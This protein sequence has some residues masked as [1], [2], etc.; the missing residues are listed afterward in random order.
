M[1]VGHKEANKCCLR[2]LLYVVTNSAAAAAVKMWCQG[3][4][5]GCYDRGEV[6]ANLDNFFPCRCTLLFKNNFGQTIYEV[7]STT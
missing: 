5:G 3:L 2:V 4:W 6:Y 7:V 1:S